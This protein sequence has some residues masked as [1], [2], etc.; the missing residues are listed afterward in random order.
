MSIQSEIERINNN[1]QTTLSTIADT[2]V[3]VGSGS[4]ALPAAAAAL[5]NE[6]QNK[7]T[8]SGLLKGDGA[9]GVS[10][11]VPGTDYT[12]PANVSSQIANLLNRTN[13]VNAAN[14]SYTTFMARGIALVASDNVD[15]VSIPANGCVMLVYQV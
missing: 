4:D 8:A 13:A 2:G 10:S 1:V 11:A 14:T 6:K 12:T 9:G 5:A 15:N 7:I 3:E